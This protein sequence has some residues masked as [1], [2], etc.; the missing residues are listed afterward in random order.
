MKFEIKSNVSNQT[1][2]P[3]CNS[4]SKLRDYNTMLQDFGSFSNGLTGLVNNRVGVVF[5]C[6]SQVVFV[7]CFHC[8]V[9]S[10]SQPRHFL[11][12]FLVFEGKKQETFPRGKK[13]GLGS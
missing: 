7:P 10:R 5:D 12:L 8:L 11:F 3:N 1:K 2:N 9:H 13:R 4:K 6:S